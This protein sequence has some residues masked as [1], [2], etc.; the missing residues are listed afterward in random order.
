MAKQEIFE[1]KTDFGTG[2]EKLTSALHS[3]RGES[4]D[5]RSYELPE[6]N[7]EPISILSPE[8]G[9][10]I[11]RR[12]DEMEEA[13]LKADVL[14]KQ[15]FVKVTA[16]SNPPYIAIPITCTEEKDII[17]LHQ[18]KDALNFTLQK[19]CELFSF[20]KN[21][22]AVLAGKAKDGQAIIVLIPGEGHHIS[23]LKK[24]VGTFKMADD[25]YR[26]QKEKLKTYAK[27]TLL[28][29]TFDILNDNERVFSDGKRTLEVLPVNYQKQS[30]KVEPTY[31]STNEYLET[32][33]SG[34]ETP[35]KAK[36]AIYSNAQTYLKDFLRGFATY[37]NEKTGRFLG[38]GDAKDIN[39]AILGTT[40]K[41]LNF[42]A[43][44]TFRL[45]KLPQ[46]TFHFEIIRTP[47]NQMYISLMDE[48]Q[49]INILNRKVKG[50]STPDN[51]SE[52]EKSCLNYYSRKEKALR[53]VL[54]DVTSN[55]FYTR[56][57]HS[58]QGAS[59]QQRLQLNTVS[60]LGR[61]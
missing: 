6:I 15:F 9:E 13:Y 2:E 41:L 1:T 42:A 30:Q 37:A 28:D 48:Q 3:E 38:L 23:D 55:I 8:W 56:S 5:K 18:T 31:K 11:V 29:L 27:K 46:D 47:D 61:E 36:E 10:S 22:F 24:A 19:V 17:T 34:L 14:L 59:H 40:C 26:H 54:V 35:A 58:S 60:G 33:V 57:H 20:P 52:L 12:Y 49:Q 45:A 4:I 25:L 21:A 43:E 39:I 50:F 16:K 44:T 51:A 32:L 53:D 7:K